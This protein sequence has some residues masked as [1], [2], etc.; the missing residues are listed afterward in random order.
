MRT[1]CVKCKKDTE[2]IDPKSFKTKNN[3]LIMQSKFRV[4]KNKTSPFV[5]D[6][7]VK[8]LLSTLVIN[9]P[10]GKVLLLNVLF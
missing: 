1:S 8:A 5:K 9:A 10:F 6:Q 4:C 7:D 3:R 2:N